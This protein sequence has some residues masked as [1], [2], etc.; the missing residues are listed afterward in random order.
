MVA[1]LKVL[2]LSE[3]WRAM[4]EREAA[5]VPG[6]AGATGSFEVAVDRDGAES[7]S[8]AIV[9]VDGV[10]QRVSL[11]ASSTPADVRVEMPQE[12][13]AA[14]LRGDTDPVYKAYWVG[15]LRATGNMAVTAAI[16][17]LLDTDGFRALLQRVHDLTTF[18][19]E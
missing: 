15:R 19:Q 7:G 5:G 4:F 11:G 13:V 12:D 17:P 3:D 1:P 8:F 18:S 14:L 6:L 16:A 2:F 9:L 10:V